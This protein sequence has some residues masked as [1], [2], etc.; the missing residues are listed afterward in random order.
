MS[1]LSKLTASDLLD[2]IGTRCAT[3][4]TLA[5][6]AA[7]AATVKSTGAIIYT[8]GGVFYTAAALANKAI[9]VTHRA[10]GSAVTAKDAAYVQPAGTTAV[11]VLALNAAG[12]LAV[13]QGS[14]AGQSITFSADKSKVITGTGAAPS[15][16]AGYCPIG[17]I[18]VKT[19]AGTTFTPAT[20]A[21]DAAGLTVTFTDLSQLPLTL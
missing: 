14:Y 6:N 21:L 3:K 10:D 7:S 13:V 17:A 12:T 5:I 20:T 19:A 9:T 11:Y 16:P 4:I 2:A 8:I 18:K 15:L 1:D